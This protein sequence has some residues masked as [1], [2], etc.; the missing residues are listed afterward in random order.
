MFGVGKSFL[1]LKHAFF[2]QAMFS[3]K[4]GCVKKV[5]EYFFEIL[6]E[7]KTTQIYTG[8]LMDYIRKAMTA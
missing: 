6:H 1:P 8:V 2:V 7:V 3:H 5:L 4:I